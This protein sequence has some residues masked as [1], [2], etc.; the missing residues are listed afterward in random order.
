MPVGT[1]R[2]GRLPRAWRPGADL[3]G[4]SGSQLE[5][6]ELASNI[7]MSTLDPL[8]RLLGGYPRGTG[9]PSSP[10]STHADEA[11]AFRSCTARTRW[12]TRLR[13]CRTAGEHGASRSS[14]TGS[15]YPLGVVGLG[16]VVKRLLVR[17][18][19]RFRTARGVM[20]FF[21]HSLWSATAP[22][23]PRR[24]RPRLRVAPPCLPWRARAPRGAGMSA[25]S[26][27]TS[28]GDPSPYTPGRSRVIDV[29]PA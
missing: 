19:P 14:L 15:Q 23:R 1:H 25:R 18:A 2:H 29:V 28:A 10:T 12:P 16:C 13:P 8:H 26:A 24:G 11:D 20:L 17:C 9:A 21:G 27:G 4:W 3:Q 5:G 7:T 6:I 22:P